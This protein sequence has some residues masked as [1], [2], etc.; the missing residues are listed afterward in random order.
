MV[1]YGI[2]ERVKVKQPGF[3]VAG[4]IDNR[5][6]GHDAVFASE[7]QAHNYLLDQVALNPKMVEQI[8]VIPNFEAV[9]P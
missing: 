1:P 5:A 2:D 8:H 9:M 7:A 6:L 3:A 4:V